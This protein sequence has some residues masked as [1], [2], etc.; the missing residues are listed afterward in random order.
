[1]GG[2]PGTSLWTGAVGAATPG[3]GIQDSL[4]IVGSAGAAGAAGGA[5]AMAT[6]GAA[7]AAGAGA[8]AAEAWESARFGD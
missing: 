8:G 4:Y 5:G 1:L 2:A 3:A 6:G 7:T